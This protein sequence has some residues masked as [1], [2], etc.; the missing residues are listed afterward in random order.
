MRNFITI[1]FS[2]ETVASRAFLMHI[3]Y[4]TVILTERTDRDRQFRNRFLYDT[5]RRS[6]RYRHRLQ[7]S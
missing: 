1:S 6:S 2:C 5:Q 3:N 4:T 7:N